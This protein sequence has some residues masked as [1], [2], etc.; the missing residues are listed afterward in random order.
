CFRVPV[1]RVNTSPQAYLCS[2]LSVESE[3]VKRKHPCSSL[4]VIR[5]VVSDIVVANKNV[6]RYNTS[7]RYAHRLAPVAKDC[8]N[9]FYL[10]SNQSMSITAA[11][12]NTN[13]RIT[14]PCRK[15]T[16]SS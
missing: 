15:G 11:S 14:L 3:F 5:C 13:T 16:P 9:H 2:S 6:L 7:Y 10:N 4:D 1:L 12:L 8:Y